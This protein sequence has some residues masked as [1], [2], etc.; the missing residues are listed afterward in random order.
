LAGGAKESSI[1]GHVFHRE[2]DKRPGRSSGLEKI[3]LIIRNA[4]QRK[5]KD[6][7]SEVLSLVSEDLVVLHLPSVIV[8]KVF[9][10]SLL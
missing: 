5:G 1:G 2:E 10:G 4:S 9:Y 8:E 6:R 3:L 7:V